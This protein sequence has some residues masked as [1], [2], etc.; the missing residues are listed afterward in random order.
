MKIYLDAALDAAVRAE[1][2]GSGVTLSAFVASALRARLGLPLAP[3]PRLP[4]ASAGGA[5]REKRT[6]AALSAL[7]AWV[8]ENPPPVRYKVDRLHNADAYLVV[9]DRGAAW[10]LVV[11]TGSRRQRLPDAVR[12]GCGTSLDPNSYA[13][14]VS[15]RFLA[16]V[17]GEGIVSSGQVVNDA[18]D[19]LMHGER[20]DL[21][22]IG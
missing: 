9:R 5:T 1:A 22:K 14:R 8:R 16:Y 18:S 7:L 15:R 10:S 2:S 19:E 20:N 12:M 4:R 17:T 6:Q 21:N 3:P 11:L 13:I